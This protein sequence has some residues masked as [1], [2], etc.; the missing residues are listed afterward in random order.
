[1]AIL[2]G[3]VLSSILQSDA[4]DDNDN[5]DDDRNLFCDSDVHDHISRTQPI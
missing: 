2:D 1:M 5:G 3:I 4:D